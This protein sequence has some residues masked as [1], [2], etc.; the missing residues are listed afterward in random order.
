MASNPASSASLWQYVYAVDPE[1]VDDT[2]N[3]FRVIVFVGFG[4]L[5]PMPIFTPPGPTSPVTLPEVSN[6]SDGTVSLATSGV[7]AT[8]KSI[9]LD[10]LETIL[11]TTAYAYGP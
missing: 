6:D 3:V 11:T 5:A 1:D 2:P 10:A 9:S 7:T 8:S 4:C